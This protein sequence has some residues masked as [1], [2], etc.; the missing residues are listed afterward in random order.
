MYCLIKLN[1]KFEKK[2]R[3]ATPNIYE[4]LNENLLLNYFSFK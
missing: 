2:K 1:F 4:K 3:I